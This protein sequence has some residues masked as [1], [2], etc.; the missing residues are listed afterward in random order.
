MWPRTEE[1]KSRGR[2]SGFVAFMR[3]E[4]GEKALHTNNGMEIMGCVL[5]TLFGLCGNGGLA[6]VPPALFGPCGNGGL[7]GRR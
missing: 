6:G 7:A 4:D 3:R 2:M 5:P 1:E